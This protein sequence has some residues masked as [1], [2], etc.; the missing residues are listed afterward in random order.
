MKRVADI[1]KG[2]AVVFTAPACLVTSLAV[3]DCDVSPTNSADVFN[4]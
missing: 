2:S 1:R 4:T 3:V